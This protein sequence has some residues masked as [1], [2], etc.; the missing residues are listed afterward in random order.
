MGTFLGWIAGRYDELQQR[1]HTRSREVRGQGRGRAV[2]ARLPAAL[3]E[4]QSGFALWLEFA[5]E[6]G[7]ICTAE[8][9]ELEQRCERAFQ[10]LAAL[11]TRYHQASEPA[12]RFV[13]LLKAAL[14]CGRAH[15]ANRRGTAPESPEASGW[16]C[17]PTSQGWI[18]QGPR[19][20]W[21][22][23]ND[24]F[25]EPAASYQ[26][27]QAVAGTE[28]IPMSQQILHHRLREGGLLL[29]V[30]RGRQMVR[31]SR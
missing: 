26:I 11:Q 22:I 1:L 6:T 27:A 13:G 9:M 30:D 7:A 29:S 24:L 23:G 3:A 25:L 8:R 17:K 14:A 21:V 28:C 4:L 16:R 2:H 18:P 12:L 10:E 20:G 19:I 31:V 15:V 5:F